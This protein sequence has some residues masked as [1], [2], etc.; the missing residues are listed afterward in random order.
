MPLHEV[1]ESNGIRT[2]IIHSPDAHDLHKPPYGIA[3]CAEGGINEEHIA[4]LSAVGLGGWY[5]T[6]SFTQ[7]DRRYSGYV[8]AYERSIEFGVCWLTEASARLFLSRPI[9]L[10]EESNGES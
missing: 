9:E 4:V 6:Y 1:L 2:M 8:V 5:S 10:S 7:G 3:V